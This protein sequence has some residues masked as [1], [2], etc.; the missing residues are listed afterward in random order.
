MDTT[1][2]KEQKQEHKREPVAFTPTWREVQIHFC[3]HNPPPPQT[4][5]FQP[6]DLQLTLGFKI[7]LAGAIYSLL[8]CGLIHPTS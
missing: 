4:P 8:S 7:T 5:S 1:R 3:F 2:V 6:F